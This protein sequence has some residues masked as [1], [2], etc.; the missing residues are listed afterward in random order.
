MSEE[1]RNDHAPRHSFPVLKAAV[2][3][4]AFES[5]SEGMAEIQNFPQAG[6]V[7]I[8]THD[9]RFYSHVARD[10]EIESPGIPPQDLLHVFLK[11]GEHM[12][13]GNDGVLDDLRKAAAK[14][15][16]WESAEQL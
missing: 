5:M 3:R 15:T 13:I 7:F 14:F 16:F 8:T 1:R 12:R 11:E 10:Q 9:A 4:H 2:L 6:L